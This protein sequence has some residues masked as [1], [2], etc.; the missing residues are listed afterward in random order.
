[1][2][3]VK[4]TIV[5]LIVYGV[6]KSINLQIWNIGVAEVLLTKELMEMRVCFVKG[7]LILLKKD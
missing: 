7:V 2:I 1:V 3:I 6:E 5:I 4:T